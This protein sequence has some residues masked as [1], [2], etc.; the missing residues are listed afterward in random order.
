[1]SQFVTLYSH[2]KIVTRK[3]K[4]KLLPTFKL[5][6]FLSKY[7]HRS[8]EYNKTFTLLSLHFNLLKID[9]MNNR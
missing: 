7:N 1:M 9:L 6:F 8:Y 3:F 2:F 5:L 4:F